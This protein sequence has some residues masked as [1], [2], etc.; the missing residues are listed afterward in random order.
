MSNW[1]IPRQHRQDGVIDQAFYLSLLYI[2]THIGDDVL[3][4]VI[5]NAWGKRQTGNGAICYILL[6]WANIIFVAF[7]KL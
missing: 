4:L 2:C 3:L 5:G 1:E 6:L 7:S